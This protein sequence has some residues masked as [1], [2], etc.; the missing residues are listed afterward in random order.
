MKL[1]YAELARKLGNGRPLGAMELIAKLGAH[2]DNGKHC[3]LIEAAIRECGQVPE[4]A[5]KRV[6]MEEARG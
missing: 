3:P 1:N 4:P 2:I 5:A 6:C